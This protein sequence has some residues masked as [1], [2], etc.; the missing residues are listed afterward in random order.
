MKEGTA[1]VVEIDPANTGQGVE[2]GGQGAEIG[3]QGA[4]IGGQGAE[5]GG[6]GAEIGDCV[7]MS[8]FLEMCRSRSRDGRSSSSERE[9][10]HK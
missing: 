9:D 3:G 1:P 5:I 6:Q 2:I 4:E 10:S 7:C 8:C